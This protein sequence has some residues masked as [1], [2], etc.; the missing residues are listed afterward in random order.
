MLTPI[1]QRLAELGGSISTVQPGRAAAHPGRRRRCEQLDAAVNAVLERHDALRLRLN[2]PVADAVVA[3]NHCGDRPSRRRQSRCHAGSTDDELRAAIGAESDAAADRLDPDA[4][5]VVQAVWFDLGARAA[6]PAAARR[7]T[8]CAVDGVSWRI[9]IDDLAEA[10]RQ[11]RAG[12]PAALA[13]G[14]DVDSRLRPDRRREAPSRRR[15]WRSS[16]TGPRRWR[17][18]ASSTPAANRRPDRRRHPGPRDSLTVAETVPLLTTVPALANADV[19]ETLVTALQ[20]AVRRWRTARGGAADAPLVLDLERHGRDGW[21]ATISTSPA[22]SAGSPRSPGAAAGHATDDPLDVLKEVKER[23]RAAP[24][25]G[26]GFGQLRYCNPRTAAALGRAAEPAGAVQLPR[27]VGGRRYRGLGLGTRDRRAAQLAPIRTSARR[28][29]WRSTPSATRPSTARCCARRSPTP[30]ASWAP[31]P[32]SSLGEPGLAALRE[33]GQLRRRA[34]DRGALTPSD[35]PLV[36]LSP[37]RRRPD[38]RPR[39]RRVEDDLAAVAAAGGRVL[40]GR[41]A[42]AAVY[43]VQNV[44]DFAE[45]VDVDRAAHR[46]LGGAGAQPG[47]ALGLPRRRPA[48]AGASRSRGPD[49]PIPR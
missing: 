39:R 12:Q 47:A 36:A 18:A 25:G 24:D 20:L 35:L 10:C 4:G 27:P 6:G 34:T 9:L 8:T 31:T 16:S 37:G 19:T 43:T 38:H 41:Y 17:P 33:L 21:D 11:V 30:T 32:S 13:A 46:V 49:V 5:V 23:L 15:D 14:P 48:A 28:T 2:R 45:P 3:G 29:C 1:V 42:K 26:L 40:P 22:P 7:C 44:F